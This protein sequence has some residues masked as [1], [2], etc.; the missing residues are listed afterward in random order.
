MAVH[1]P[2]LPDRSGPTLR[3]GAAHPGSTQIIARVSPAHAEELR[4]CLQAQEVEVSELIELSVSDLVPFLISGWLARNVL[5]I[6][7]TKFFER[8]KGKEVTIWV[9]GK[10][11]TPR[12]CSTADITKMVT[13]VQQQQRELDALYAD[14]LEH[15]EGEPDGEDKPDP[16]APSEPEST[17]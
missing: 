16:S 1:R 17:T 5:T 15:R 8:H 9:D 3:L 14:R 12:D 6:A 10:F 4:A 13:A 2:D 11:I 7:I